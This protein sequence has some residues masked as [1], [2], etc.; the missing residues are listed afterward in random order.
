MSTKTKGP[1]VFVSHANA[2]GDYVKYFVNNILLRGAQLRPREVFYSSAADM[3]V[4]SG[5]HLMERVRAE[6]GD[7]ELI[8]AMV[9]PTYQKRPVCVAELGA[10][11]SRD[12]LFPLLA[13]NMGR[14]E[15]EGVL[16]GVLIRP[17]D[18]E[19][20][21]DELA[22]RITGLGFQ[23]SASSFGQGKAEWQ[24]ELRR[25]LQP[26]ALPPDPDPDELKNLELRLESAQKAL[27]AAKDEL[28]EEKERNERLKAAKTSAEARQASL[29]TDESER[30][31]AL[32]EGVVA[33]RRGLSD[34]VFDAVWH[35]VANHTMPLPERAD[36]ANVHDSII[37]EMKAGR[38]RL[39]E[40]T[41]EIRP[42]L[43]FPKVMRARTAIAELAEFLIPEDRSEAF[44]EWFDNEYETPM[45][46]RM[47]ACWDALI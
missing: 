37:S 8:I 10:A 38:L 28:Q 45:D 27:D 9:T 5:E 18:D 13:P 7:S 42:N 14:S 20:V 31:E 12:V 33:A 34:V 15:L 23:V 22:D 29:P 17:A 19:D 16:P 41:G 47:K 43:D 2:D 46:L 35:D 39:D 36:Y 26:A 21:L 3:G 1:K 24:S 25:G 11:W 4:K 6:A 40:D 30:F 32:R 44:S